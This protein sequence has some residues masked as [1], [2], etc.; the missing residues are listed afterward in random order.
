MH[1]QSVCEA[2]ITFAQVENDRTQSGDDG[3]ASGKF[4][5]ET[6]RFDLVSSTNPSTRL[7][8]QETEKQNLAL[9]HVLE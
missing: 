7:L 8:V 6:P 9:G 5:C 2:R 3:V 1:V 4:F